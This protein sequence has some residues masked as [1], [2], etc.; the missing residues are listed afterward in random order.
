MLIAS[1]ALICAGFGM[2]LYGSLTTADNLVHDTRVIGKF[3]PLLKVHAYLDPQVNPTGVILV[4]K[5]SFS[6]SV[7]VRVLEPHGRAILSETAEAATVDEYFDIAEA[8]TYT[9]VIRNEVGELSVSGSIG[10]ANE[11]WRLSLGPAGIAM[12]AVG[13]AWAVAVISI[14]LKKALV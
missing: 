8:G 3:L 7:D 1:G 6:G 5:E 10:Y 12:L 9:L 14:I 13:T 2:W 11:A 4:E